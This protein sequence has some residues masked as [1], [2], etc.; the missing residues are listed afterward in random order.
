M[1]SVGKDPQISVSI[2]VSNL[3]LLVNFFLFP[4]LHLMHISKYEN[5]SCDKFSSFTKCNFPC[6]GN[7]AYALNNDATVLMKSLVLVFCKFSS[8]LNDTKDSIKW[9]LKVIYRGFPRDNH[10][11]NIGI[12]TSN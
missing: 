9:L 1:M 11:Q 8:M 2:Y 6:N 5:S 4:F 10:S 7:M 12:E 3:E